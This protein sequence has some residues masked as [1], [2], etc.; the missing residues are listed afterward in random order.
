MLS[1]ISSV[2]VC[3]CVFSGAGCG[4]PCQHQLSDCSQVCSLH[5]QRELL[6]PHPSGPQQSSL[7][8]VLLWT[9]FC[10]SFLFTP[11]L[12]QIRLADL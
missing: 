11:A 6:L 9:H 12:V 3:V 4:K 5:P 7:S 8:G 2:F 10:T 1:Y